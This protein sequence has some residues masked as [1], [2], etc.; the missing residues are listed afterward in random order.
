MINIV[1]N[2]RQRI[3]VYIK[4]IRKNK[5]KKNETVNIDVVFLRGNLSLP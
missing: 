2:K 3:Y 4:I 5:Q 1:S